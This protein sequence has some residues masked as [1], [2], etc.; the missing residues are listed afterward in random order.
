[1]QRG[2]VGSEMCIRDRYQR[3]VHGRDYMEKLGE[4]PIFSAPNTDEVERKCKEIIA[5][6]KTSLLDF[7]EE[8]AARKPKA[9]ALLDRN[10]EGIYK[11]I[12]Y[13]EMTHQ[14]QCLGKALMDGKLVPDIEIN[15]MK[16]R[17]LGTLLINRYEAVITDLTALYT[18]SL[19]HI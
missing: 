7:V 14:S 12:T 18:L 10:S 1:M 16:M 5:S 4:T 17:F 9:V 19:I 11:K 2:L 15:G 3:R 8:V 6:G 13:E